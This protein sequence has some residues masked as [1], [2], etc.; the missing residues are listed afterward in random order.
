[1]GGPHSYIFS[2]LYEKLC[3]NITIRNTKI[4][5]ELHIRLYLGITSRPVNNKRGGPVING[6]E[7]YG[8]R[9]IGKKSVYNHY[10]GD[11]T[12][13]ELPPHAHLKYL[14]R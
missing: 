11:Q 14:L 13:A 10:S 5:G 6:R 1:M 3:D 9:F 8:E 2:F 7:R 12:L 4:P